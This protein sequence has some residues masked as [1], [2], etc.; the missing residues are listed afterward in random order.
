MLL[1][2]TQ[3]SK[4]TPA[5]V[6]MLGAFVVN[7]GN[8][9]YNVILGRMLGPEAFADAA[10]L[11]TFLL[12]LSFMAMTFQLGTAKFSVVFSNKTFRYF[13]AMMY[14]YALLA[15]SIAGTLLI[16]FAK[17]LQQLFH[18]QSSFMFIV[19]GVG[20]PVYFALSVNRG[21]FQG[22]QLFVPLTITYQT[23]MWSR[24]LVT[25]LLL[26]LFTAAASVWV[27]TGIA[28]SFF[29]GLIPFRK[30]AGGTLKAFQ[31][32]ELTHNRKII[33]FLLITG[34][35]ECTQILINNSDIIMVKHF[36]TSMEA[37]LYASLALIGRMVYF[38]AWMFVMQLLPDVVKREK[39]GQPHKQILVKYAGYVCFLSAVVVITCW[40]FP[41][42]VVSLMFG[43]AYLAI[44]G[45]L[46]KYALATSMFAISNIF[47]YY[48]LSLE[49]YIPVMISGVA[50][51][52]QILLIFF[53]HKS[54]E[55]VVLMQIIVMGLLFWVQLT[56]YQIYT[57]KK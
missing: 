31:F 22:K 38:V 13:H 57:L 28:V 46:W 40:L 41:D 26:W 18:T 30:P 12:I 1:S 7:A 48:F 49:K 29:F 36:F 4:I 11:I 45:L 50:G 10:L 44:G 47:V 15:G 19:F 27:A 9:L 20:I 14:K 33:N 32:K 25:L 52:C 53:Y 2:R 3:T 5:K 21:V 23:E 56:F 35:Y 43:D 54:L 16:I 39:D 8:Y 42:M 6:F 17:D 37:G 24:L 55:Q 51:F 34:F